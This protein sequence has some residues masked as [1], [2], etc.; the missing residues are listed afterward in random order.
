MTLCPSLPPI[1]TTGDPQATTTGSPCSCQLNDA[2][3]TPRLGHEGGRCGR[4]ISRAAI[5]GKR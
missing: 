4:R 5:R 1:Q 3:R 2:L